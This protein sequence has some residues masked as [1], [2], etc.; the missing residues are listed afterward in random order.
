MSA[1]F[2]KIKSVPKLAV[3]LV[4]TMSDTS[5][6]TM[7]IREGDRVTNLSYITN[8]GKVETITG[9]VKVIKFTASSR[10]TQQE[11][12]HSLTSDFAARVSVTDLV[13]DCSDVYKSDIRV[14]PVSSIR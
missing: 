5:T 3:S 12:V 4:I 11:C 7:I 9:D 14:I 6:K 13:V 1:D 10:Q 8:G 2:V